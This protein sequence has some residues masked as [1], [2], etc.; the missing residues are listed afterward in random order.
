MLG[1]FSKRVLL[2]GAGWSR[3]WG[4]RLATEVWEALVGH[5][6]VRRN[7]RLRALL[8]DEQRFEVALARASVPPFTA[9]D[10]AALEHAVIDIFI[11]MDR[12]IARVQNDGPNVGRVQ[13]LVFRVAGRQGADNDTGYIFTL[14]QDFFPERHFYNSYVYFAPPPALPGVRAKPHA[15]FF[16]T[17]MAK[18]YSAEL[19]A[20]PVADLGKAVGLTG[21]T[22]IIKLHGSFNWRTSDGRNVLV[23]GDGKSAQIEAHPL[24]AWYGDIFRQVLGAG[25]VRLMIVGYGFGDEHINAAIADAVETAKLRV[26]FWDTAPDLV[27]RVKRAPHGERIWRGL[28]GKA[29]RAL[30]EVF[31]ADQSETEEWRRIK[32]EFWE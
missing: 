23:V 13:E 7:D 9:E 11:G 19:T 24:L 14:N 27:E 10:R 26:F 12:D 18:V 25:D 3:N 2:T 22:N 1:R 5:H 4:A 29:S 17:E 15:G 16:S 31:P 6:A 28:L 32:R 21:Q 20:E 8:L 30:L